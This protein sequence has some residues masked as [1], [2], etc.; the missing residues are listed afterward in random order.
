[1]TNLIIP[2]AEIMVTQVCNL[3]CPGCSTYSDLQYKGY[4]SWSQGR[5]E[6]EPWL[7]RVGFDHFGIMGGEPMVNPEIKKWLVGVRELMPETVIRFPT[8]A[9]LLHK[10]LDVVDL[11]HELGNV[12]FKITVHQHNNKKVES[13]IEYVQNKFDWEPIHEYNVHRFVTDNN[14]KFQINRP[15]KFFKTFYGEYHNAAP[16]DSDPV[17]AF[18]VCHQKE[19]PLLYNNRIYKCSTTGLMDGVLARYNYPNYELWQ[20]YLDKSLNG[21][22]GI[23]DSS[24]DIKE[25]ISNIRKPHATC[26]QCPNKTNI[27]SINHPET[28]YYKNEINFR[29]L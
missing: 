29:Q 1:M 11:L 27:Q 23:T 4:K 21:S 16:Y 22:I 14:F 15:K 19:C 13:A 7:E 8:N 18:D 9:T 2:Y 10:N 25:F 3:V 20:P 17:E 28:V 24:E 5:S 6:I 12:I 26:R